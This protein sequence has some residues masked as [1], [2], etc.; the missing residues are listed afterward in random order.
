MSDQR[1]IERPHHSGLADYHCHCDYSVDAVGTIDD[2]CRAAV[3]R[4]LAELCFTTHYD[5]NPHSE[6]KDYYIRVQDKEVPSS[7][8]ALAPYVDDVHAAAERF[9]ADGLSVKLGVEIGWFPGCEETVARLRERF[10]FHHVLCGIHE[11]NNVCFCCKGWN[12]KCFA[13]FDANGLA[14]AYFRQ[15]VAAANSG[16]FDAI[17]HLDYYRKYGDEYYGDALKTAHEPFVGELFAALQ[18]SDTALE[19]N[20]AALRKGLGEYFPR[21]S[22]LNA[23]RRAGVMVRFLGSDAHRPEDV[24]FDFDAAVTLLS[25][26]SRT[27]EV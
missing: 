5:A 13:P 12:L 21:V 24:G 10:D 6:R 3:Q 22:L 11:I 26:V 15:A 25:D 16:L 18:R 2:Y 9:L 4:G 8:D 17:A 7:P 1:P 19:I 23:A 27:C 20:T 14:E